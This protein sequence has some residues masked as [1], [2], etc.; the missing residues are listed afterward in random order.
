VARRDEIIAF[1]DELLDVDAYPD[2][3]PM[4]L[5]VVGAH[6]V[7]RIACGVSASRE[8]FERAAADGAQLV[9]VHH[10]L[11]WENES[12]VVDDRMRGRLKSLFDADLSL[13]A[14]HLAL[15]AHPEVGNNALLARELGVEP[16]RRFDQ[17][18]FGGPLTE[19][20]P[21]GEIAALLGRLLG[22]DPLVFP[23]GPEVVR[24]VAIISGGGASR[25]ALAAA[26]G[27]DLFLTGE[28]AEPTLAT[29]RE[30]GIGFVAAGHHATETLGVQALAARIAERF[31]IE[32][33][34]I[35]IDN[36]I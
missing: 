19:P 24:T 32:W 17:V 12:R 5:Q 8:L 14:Y 27:Y 9:L 6:E 3:G 15:D 22:R 28:P 33:G 26:E 29:A 1:A 11:L 2:Y 10:G 16:L 21:V 30:L 25:L 4:G 31:A 18:G 13:V 7:T 23:C 36:P 34:F 20:R 35:G